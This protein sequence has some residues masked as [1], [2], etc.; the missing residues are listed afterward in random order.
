MNYKVI[1]KFICRHS[2]NE[3]RSSFLSFHK[4][5]NIKDSRPVSMT[6]MIARFWLAIVNRHKD[7]SLI[8]HV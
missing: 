6:F 5:D 7:L 8:L 1:K 4:H 2:Q 3:V